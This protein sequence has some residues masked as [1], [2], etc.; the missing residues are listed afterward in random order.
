MLAILLGWPLWKT[1]RK[2]KCSSIRESVVVVMGYLPVQVLFLLPFWTA[3]CIIDL[4]TN[5]EIEGHVFMMGL[6]IASF[7]GGGWIGLPFS[8]LPASPRDATS[9]A[10]YR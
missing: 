6:A 8:Y 3:A 7:F 2:E 5:R 10:V 9:G 4:S 1:L